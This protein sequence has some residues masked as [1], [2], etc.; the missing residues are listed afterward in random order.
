M[1]E[2]AGPARG[3]PHAVA[4]LL[5]LLNPYV[6]V[7]TARTTIT[8]LGYAA[9][10]WL[11]VCVQARPLGAR[12][13]VAGGVRAD[14]DRVR[15][16]RERGRD[17]VGAARA[18]CCSALYERWTG[19][20]D[21]AARCGASA[22]GPRWRPALASAWWVVPLLVQSRYGVDFLRF[23]EQPGTIWSTTSL[24][25][26][27]RLMGYWI[28]YLGV[29]YGGELRPYFGD[30]GVL[31]FALPVV[32]AG[33]LV[34]AL[35][36]T[37]FAWTRKDRVRRRSRCAGARRPDRDDGRL[38]GGHAAP[39]GVELY[40]QPL[41][42]GAVPADDV[43]GGA[44]GGARASRV[45]AGLARRASRRA[46]LSR[47]LA[48]PL[49]ACWPLVRGRARRRPAAVGAR[50]RPPGRT[51]PTTSTRA[52]ATAARS[53]CPA[54]STRTTTGAARSTR[55]CPALADTP[56]AT[57]NAVGYADLRATDLLWTVDAL[58]QQRRAV[59]GQLDP[60]LDLLGARTVV[61]G[62]D[63]DRTRSGAAPAAEAADVLDQLGR[64]TRAVGRASASARARPGRS[65]RRRAARR[66][67]PGTARPR[68]AS[69]A[70]SGSRAATSSSTARPRA[71]P[72]WRPF[73]RARRNV[74]LRGRPT[75]RRRSAR[76]RGEVVI[77][78]SNRRRV[79]VPSRL[80]QNA[81][82]VLAADEEPSVDAARAQ[83]VRRAA[84]T[85]RP[86]RSTTGSRRSRAPSSPGFP[87]FPEHRPFAALDGDEATHWQADRALTPDRHVLDGR[88]RRAA[89]VGDART[90]AR[91]TTAGS[92]VTAVE[93][94]GT[95]VSGR[96]RAGTA[97]AGRAD[98]RRPTLS[99]RIVG[100]RKP[101]GRRPTRAASASCGSR[102][103]RRPRRCGRRCS[104][105]ARWPAPDLPQASR[106]CSSARPATT[107]SAA[108][109]ERGSAGAALVRDRGDARDAARARVLAAGRAHVARST[110]GRACR[111]DAPDAE[112]DRLVGV[113]GALHVAPSR[114]QGQPGL[115]RLERVRRHPAA[116]DR[117]S[118]RRTAARLARVE[119]RGGDDLAR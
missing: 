94:N 57:R 19:A 71:W 46:W 108:T 77:T 107:R 25:E 5:F 89:D 49:V 50:S 8:L 41:R 92:T 93:V 63:D 12:V 118:G 100:I 104:P 16:R 91:T 64:P 32:I 105:S 52:P 110:A 72:R 55:S 96:A 30:G 81:G 47:S 9:L 116:V 115:P 80:A 54:S 43:Q 66:C 34:P 75:R 111:D 78:D 1:D 44:A 7:F 87:Q 62:A 67:A 39:P 18:G 3:L 61:A 74:G 79:L 83:P 13:A 36:L 56:V 11:L 102:A 38:P 24:P 69:C 114:F 37:G 98:G 58:V 23:T 53:S 29:G 103:C 109:P 42:P 90:A 84:R 4:G 88:L 106:T 68:P 101:A 51:R 10:P 27:L 73:G 45:L 6:V 97:L 26:S 112:L 31:L 33:L 99:V 28:S 65:A 60:L 2:L 86:S 85:R 17:G 76:R 20:V 35:A 21:V 82:P 119:R 59:P 14:R 15:R 117:R 70:S 22:G 113:R 48:L 95:D 40:V